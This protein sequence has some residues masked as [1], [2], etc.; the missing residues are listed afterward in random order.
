MRQESLY[1]LFFHEP[2]QHAEEKR[3]HINDFVNF[4]KSIFLESHFEND[5]DVSQL[6]L[7]WNLAEETIV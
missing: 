5:K 3:G 7:Q 6:I 2:A 4:I 1:I